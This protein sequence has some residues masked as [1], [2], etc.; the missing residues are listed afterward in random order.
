M[1]NR[2]IGAMEEALSAIPIR[3]YRGHVEFDGTD[4]KDWDRKK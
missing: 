4:L 1:K 2:K 3:G